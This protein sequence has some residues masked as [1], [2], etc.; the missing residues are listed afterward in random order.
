[1]KNSIRK[2]LCAALALLLILG[3]VEVPYIPEDE[4]AAY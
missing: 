4:Q 2:L 3:A 1:M